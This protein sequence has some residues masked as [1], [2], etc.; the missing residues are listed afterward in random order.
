MWDSSQE[1]VYFHR[2]CYRLGLR[3]SIPL[4][5][6]DAR[7]IALLNSFTRAWCGIPL[8]LT[9]GQGGPEPFSQNAPYTAETTP[10]AP[11]IAADLRVRVFARAS[12]R[13][14]SSGKAGISRRGFE[15][16]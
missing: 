9:A 5:I 15:P 3:P 7:F 11:S 13:G 16:K 14:S 2:I 10:T 6:P 8:A 1:E 4:I 12:A